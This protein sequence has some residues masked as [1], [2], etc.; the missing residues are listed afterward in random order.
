MTR[1]ATWQITPAISAGA[2][3]LWAGARPGARSPS[4]AEHDELVRQGAVMKL[5][6]LLLTALFD[7]EWRAGTLGRPRRRYAN[8]AYA[9]PSRRLMG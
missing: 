1:T 5:P 8:E 2:R 4:P 9:I 7:V 3:L 6:F